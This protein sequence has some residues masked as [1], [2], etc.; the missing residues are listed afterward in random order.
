MDQVIR[1]WEN[2]NIKTG[3]NSFI[4]YENLIKFKIFYFHCLISNEKWINKIVNLR[5]QNMEFFIA[6]EATFLFLF[7][8]KKTDSEEGPGSSVEVLISNLSFLHILISASSGEWAWKAV[9]WFTLCRWSWCVM[10]SYLPWNSFIKQFSFKWLGFWVLYV[11]FWIVVQ[12]ASYGGKNGNTR[13][14]CNRIL[15]CT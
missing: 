14:I 2:F 12:H 11:N 3:T 4:K 9:I 8:L 7:N 5:R 6:C 15:F 1:W 10:F 13:N